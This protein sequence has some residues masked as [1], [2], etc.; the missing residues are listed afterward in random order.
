LDGHFSCEKV[1][2]SPLFSTST[3]DEFGNRPYRQIP[4]CVMLNGLE[5]AMP[6]ETQA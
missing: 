4:R 5:A 6:V 2:G 1:G 3:D